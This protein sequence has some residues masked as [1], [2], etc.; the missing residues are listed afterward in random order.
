MPDERPARTRAERPP[1]ARM[2]LITRELW[3]IVNDLR[4]LERKLTPSQ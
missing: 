1:S 2:T 3:S 4:S